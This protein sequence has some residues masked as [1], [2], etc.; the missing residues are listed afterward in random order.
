M[1]FTLIL[2]LI[3]SFIAFLLV[4]LL[5]S[6]KIRYKITVLS[7]V[8]QI[9]TFPIMNIYLSLNFLFSLTLWTSMKNNLKNILKFKPIK[10][11]IY[12][13]LI[14]MISILWSSDIYLGIRTIVY[15]LPFLFIF[16]S[17]SDIAKNKFEY[18]MRI[19]P[20]Y[21]IFTIIESILVILFRLKPSYEELFLSSNISNI[22]IKPNVINQFGISIMNNVLDP[23]KAGGFFINANVAATFLGI[24]MFVLYGI[25]K[26]YNKNLLKYVSAFLWMAVIFTGSKM[27]LILD[28]VLPILAYLS[29][30]FKLKKIN[31]AK[32]TKSLLFLILIFIFAITFILPYLNKIGFFNNT[33][34]TFDVR[35]MIWNHALTQ[36][37]KHPILGQGFGG[38]E[39]TYSKY[40][41]S[42]GLSTGY[43]PHNTLIYL[44]SQSGIAA[45]I[46]GILF[47]VNILLYIW[48]K[49]K[50]DN[51]TIRG[52]SICFML[53]FLWLFIQGFGENFGIIGEEHMQPI[54]AFALGLLYSEV[55]SYKAGGLNNE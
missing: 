30:D 14:Q 22:F 7:T 16:F 20:L 47:I 49:S 37:E 55:E 40:A 48:D 31:Y 25:Y 18:I 4:S 9:Y 32:L 50:I 11:Y 17:T 44:W 1:D 53:A 42:I 12:L 5:L 26:A 28:I 51:E 13:I 6:E 15:L 2:L 3:T 39:I 33:N 36:F 19:L 23:A 27:G 45:L 35:L 29:F 52:L 46:L 43:P 34:H 38:W 41:L 10:I 24:N 54:L 8:F 21:T